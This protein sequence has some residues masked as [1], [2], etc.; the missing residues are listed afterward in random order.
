MFFMNGMFKCESK[1]LFAKQ[2]LNGDCVISKGKKFRGILKIAEKGFS[3]LTSPLGQFHLE[4]DQFLQEEGGLVESGLLLVERD[5][6]QSEHGL[7]AEPALPTADQSVVLIHVEDGVELVPLH[8]E[9]G[10]HVGLHR[11]V[12]FGLE[13]EEEEDKNRTMPSVPPKILS[14]LNDHV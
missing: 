12:G 9:A 11:L 5:H 3:A 2:F 13:E 14:L 1:I 7:V 10:L 8:L 4:I 6:D